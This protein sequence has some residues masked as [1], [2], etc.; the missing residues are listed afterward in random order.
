MYYNLTND[1]FTNKNTFDELNSQ[2]SQK[3]KEI[4]SLTNS[5]HNLTELSAIDKKDFQAKLQSQLK[6][7][8]L[9]NHEI[10]DQMT[11]LEERHKTALNQTEQKEKTSQKKIDKLQ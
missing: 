4:E 3:D 7:S 1:L 2:I 5:V 10:L 9:K 6:Q 8:N 11:K